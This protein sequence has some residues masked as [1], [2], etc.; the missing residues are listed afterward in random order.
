MATISAQERTLT[1]RVP[2]RFSAGLADLD[3]TLCLDRHLA[4]LMLCDAVDGV[5]RRLE[6]M[7]SHG[8]AED[9]CPGELRCIAG[10]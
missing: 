1:V 6:G 5:T 3:G 8:Y 7:M 4:G 9:I 10:R 2:E